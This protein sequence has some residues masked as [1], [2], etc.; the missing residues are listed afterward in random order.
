M[1]GVFIMDEK[2]MWIQTLWNPL[3][4]RNQSPMES[5]AEGIRV[6][7]YCRVSNDRNN[8]ESLLNQISY[9][10]NLIKSKSNWKFTGL[11]FDKG[12][13]GATYDQRPGFKRMLRHCEEGRIDL[14][15]TKSVSRFSRNTKELIDIV[16]NLK[17]KKIAIYFEKEH[18]DTALDYNRFLLNVYAALGQETIESASQLTRWGYEKRFIKGI[19]VFGNL[20]G[21]DVDKNKGNPI[22]TINEDEALVVRWIY[23]MFING[24]TY[25]EIA[26]QLVEKGIKTKK[27]KSLWA[28]E[29]VLKIIKNI[30]YTGN[31][32]A[33]TRTKDILTNDIKKG[34][35]DEFYFE[36]SHPAIIS[37]DVFDKAQI[38]VEEIARR[39]VR[40]QGT[41][42][43]RP[44]SKR[45]ICGYCG[46]TFRSRP[47]SSWRCRTTLIDRDF[48]NAQVLNDKPLLKMMLKALEQRFDFDNKD[49]LKNVLRFIQRINQNDHFE[50]HRLKHLTEIEIAYKGGNLEE[51]DR[52]IEI[53]KEFEAKVKKI[54]EDR[55]YRDKVISWLK[56]IK[57][58]EEFRKQLTIEYARAWVMEIEIYT[59]EA[60]IVQWVDEDKT[61]VGDCE[62]AKKSVVN[63]K[64]VGELENTLKVSVEDKLNMEG[65]QTKEIQNE[66]T[67]NQEGGK[68]LMPEVI[69]IRSS[70]NPMEQI[71]KSLKGHGTERIYETLSRNKKTSKTIRVA[72]YCRVSTNMEEQQVSIR[73]QTAYYTFLILKSKEWEFA[74]IFTD[75]GLSGTSMDNRTEF[76]KMID[77]CKAGKI[78]LIITKSISRFSRNTLEALSIIR[79]LKSL[80]NPVYCYFEKE[81]INSADD[82][83]DLL[84]SL[85]LSISQEEVK[86][87]SQ[88]VK[89]G[90]VKLAQRGIIHRT[91]DIYGYT[92]DKNRNWNVVSEEAEVIRFIATEFLSGKPYNEIIETLHDKGIKSPSGMDYW[93]DSQIREMLKNEKYKGDYL[94]QKSYTPDIIGVKPKRN[95]G[96]VAQYYIEKHHPGII[97]EREW[98]LIQ[99][100]MERRTREPVVNPKPLQTAG[101][102][103]FYQKFY[104][105]ECGSLISRY[106]SKFRTREG[107]NWRCYDT[108]GKINS[109]CNNSKGY[110]QEYIELNFM[111]TL[112]EID[113]IQ[114]LVDEEIKKL[115]L[116]KEELLYE[117]EV[118]KEIEEL[119]QQ[120]YIAVDEELNK[121]G[122]DTKKIDF[123]TERIIYLKNSLKEFEVR[124]DKV[125]YYKEEL[126]E[127]L[128]VCKKLR[129]QSVRQF[130]NMDVRIKP[131]DSIYDTTKNAKDST[132]VKDGPE[133]F[134]EDIFEKYITKGEIDGEG[135]ITYTFI[136]DIRYG[137]NMTYEEYLEEFE[138]AKA[139][140]NFEEL[141]IS[142]EVRQLT[143]FCREGKTPKEMREL[144]KISSRVSFDK[145]IL[146]PLYNA[147]RFTLVRGKC[148][149]DWR[150]SW[151]C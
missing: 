38:R 113:N 146:R 56:D 64:E 35:R 71:R 134:R 74:G 150:Y 86:N 45:I 142:N 148:P 77:D 72:A 125:K 12:I 78:D 53:Y 55:I 83:S 84:L 136:F 89:W 63:I 81:N 90:I 10:T 91:T 34:I 30:T 103:S 6:V 94:F 29:Q 43:I 16:N 28:K 3:N 31:K 98:D 44:F 66:S 122:Q 116:T 92:I 115:T 76:N 129:P 112:L 137:I 1:K 149:N 119:S 11:Y 106:R 101:R 46:G 126:K 144:L 58:I 42:N 4:E 25:S 99:E 50:F 132:Y 61:V 70:Q 145:R 97:E 40:R 100:E 2:T 104:C 24:S 48:C 18:I 117:S 20:Y 121:H 54:E 41:Y 39:N 127:L 88:N 36:N 108:Y 102:K 8:L 51:A 68:F 57:T 95:N 80:P 5:K 85:Y 110:R 138:K 32:I 87:I 14:I 65:Y 37:K 141:L 139:D 131:G 9:F 19:P 107:S 22:V 128:R 67:E 73:S 69:K 120:L 133:H 114:T 111:K 52:L 135:R 109:Q 60:Y 96:E 130:H 147:G 124:R 143:T 123:L 27:G 59:K 7:A 21:Y 13:S 151:N 15:L 75:E 62:A 49:I 79:M 33:R 105:N 82:K 140:I 17:E 93:N 23:D 47:P 26:K 118:K